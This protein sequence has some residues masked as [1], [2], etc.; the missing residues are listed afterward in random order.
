MSQVAATVY[1]WQ[2][3]SDVIKQWKIASMERIKVTANITCR[4]NHWSLQVVEENVEVNVNGLPLYAKS[5]FDLSITWT[6]A[7][8]LGRDD[9]SRKSY[10]MWYF[11]TKQEAEKF[12]TL[13]TLK[14][15]R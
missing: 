8:L 1:K 13:F 12:K 6:E 4:D 7:Q 5:L 3:V 15:A 9:V 10:D 14:W 2:A 11:S